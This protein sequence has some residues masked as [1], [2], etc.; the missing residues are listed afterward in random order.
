M[1]AYLCVIL[2]IIC[3]FSA[4]CAQAKMSIRSMYDGSQV[5]EL[6]EIRQLTTLDDGIVEGAEFSP[7]GKSIAYTSAII[8]KVVDPGNFDYQ[9]RI[10]TVSSSGGRPTVLFNTA[11]S[12]NGV[13]PPNKDVIVPGGLTQFVWSP[14]SRSIA[15]NVG[16]C[17]DTIDNQWQAILMINRNGSRRGLIDLPKRVYII[18]GLVWS[19]S[20]RKIAALVQTPP[21][22]PKEKPARNIVL[23]D[24]ISNVPPIVLMLQLK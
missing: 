10:V 8:G 18:G 24:T 4:M 15:L 23:Y 3:I 19:P 11:L 21:G 12:A 1:K 22:D 5:I 2:A 6:A 7:D 17:R 14:D 9:A 16:V 13:I 20:S